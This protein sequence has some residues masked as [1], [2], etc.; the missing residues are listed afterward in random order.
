MGLTTKQKEVYQYIADYWQD[1]GLA[2]T[3]REIKDHFELKS[4]G[5]VQRYIKYLMEAGLLEGGDWNERRGLKPADVAEPVSQDS[6]HIPLIGQIA[7]GN[8]IE[9]IEQADETIAVPK[10]ML[11]GRG[12][13]FALKVKGDSM[14]EAGI[15]NGDLAILRSSK[16]ANKGSI[17]AAVVDGEATLKHFY[18]KGDKI[19]LH[20]ANA[21][22]RPI[23][24]PASKTCIAGVLVGLWRSYGQAR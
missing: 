9:A 3:Q 14:I 13:F 1:H 23:V 2:P 18:P 5:S 17:I 21:Q 15:L 11:S 8:P 24:V 6:I 12:T 20:P 19:E 16:E 10:S 7:A 4:F 22:M